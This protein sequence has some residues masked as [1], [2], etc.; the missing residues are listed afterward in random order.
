MLLKINSVGI[1]PISNI[2]LSLSLGQS[3]F[4]T[5]YGHKTKER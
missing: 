2:L 3:D 5:G 1:Q 4:L